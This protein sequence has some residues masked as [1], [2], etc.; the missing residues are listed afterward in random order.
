MKRFTQND[1]FLEKNPTI[2]N[3]PIDSLKLKAGD[4]TVEY[5]LLANIIHEGKGYKQAEDTANELLI[6][7]S[8]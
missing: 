1:F 8:K 3:F 4:E 5:E 7:T 6:N 2:V